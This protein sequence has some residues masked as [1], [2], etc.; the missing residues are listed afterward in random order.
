MPSPVLG[1]DYGDRRIGVAVGQ[2]FTGTAQPVAVVGNG[3]K[4]PEWPRIDAL[5]RE[6]SPQALVVGRPLTLDG[7]EQLISRRATAFGKQL[8]ERFKLPVIAQD[9]RLSSR[10]ASARFAAARK[11]GAKRQRDA[12]L[13]DAIAA[14]V[15][16]E[17]F[18][19]SRARVAPS[20]D[21]AT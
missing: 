18:F 5:V 14:Q 6:W 2:S 11:A 3:D 20:P 10:E 19:L 7:E 8:G 21:H 9:E 4:G 17:D 16:V 15:I 1:F 12:A 13:H